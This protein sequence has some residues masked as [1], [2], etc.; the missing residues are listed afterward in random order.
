MCTIIRQIV[1][2]LQHRVYIVWYNKSLNIICLERCVP[3]YCILYKYYNNNTLTS[4]NRG[5]QYLCVCAC[6]RPCNTSH[7]MHR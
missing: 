6:V 1:A 7:H 4:I 5:Y 3:D 2:V